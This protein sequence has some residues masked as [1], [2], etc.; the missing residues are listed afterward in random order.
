MRVQNEN[1]AGTVGWC[2][3]P[4]DLAVSKLLAG[5]PKDVE[6]VSVM[7]RNGLTIKSAITNVL[8]ELPP[9]QSN[10]AAARLAQCH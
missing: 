7:L 9:D 6:F 2:L 4:V 1:T 5:R 3:S 8:S 10:L